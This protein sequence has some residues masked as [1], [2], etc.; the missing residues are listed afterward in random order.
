MVDNAGG[1][2][3]PGPLSPPASIA[4]S[5]L[6]SNRLPQP[7]TAGPLRSGSRSE[8]ALIQ[9][10]DEELLQVGR[11]YVKKFSPGGYSNIKNV[12]NDLEKLVDILWIS[13]TPTLQTQY[14][15]N[16]A[17]SFND[18]L[19]SFKPHFKSTF[20]LLDKLDRCFYTLITGRPAD[21]DVAPLS[22]AVSVFRLNMTEKVRLK[23]V[24]ERTRLNVV[25]LAESGGSTAVS[26]EYIDP[27]NSNLSE[28]N[29]VHSDED[30][31]EIDDE[32]LE[33]QVEVTKIYDRVLQEIGDEL[34]MTGS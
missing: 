16:I 24:V 5:I 7:R 30:F 33:W 11:K 29:S 13:S 26:N 14:F 31:Y 8:T 17:N 15:L 4:S 28:A 23:S 22:P 18:Y 10:M 21:P 32:E 2:L 27:D 19:Y 25:N 1:F 20:Q 12:A 3:E 34:V 6:S 9:Y